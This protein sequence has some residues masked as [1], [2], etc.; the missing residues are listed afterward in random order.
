MILHIIRHGET[1]YNKAGIIQGSGVN[2]SLNEEGRKQAEAFYKMYSDEDYELIYTSA[3]KRSQETVEP[4]EVENIP[5]KH[6]ELL[7]EINW[8]VNEGKQV[9]AAMTERYTRLI[10]DWEKGELTSRIEGGESAEELLQRLSDFLEMLR[11]SGHE[12]VLICS[13]GRTIRALLTLLL[14]LEAGDMK[15]FNHSN[16]GLFA[17]QVTE[18]SAVLLKKND[19]SH[20]G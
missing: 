20:L 12:K 7:N 18:D 14:G 15:R 3:L 5:I 4:W 17:L 6:T 16:T 2:I 9:S 11:R 8:G 1:D 10:D 13:H 19:V